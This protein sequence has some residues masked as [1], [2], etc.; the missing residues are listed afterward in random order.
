MLEL[1]NKR[2]ST[3]PAALISF[4]LALLICGL[5]PAY[6]AVTLTSSGI[7]GKALPRFASPGSRTALQAQQVASS[8]C[9]ADIDGD[10]RDEVLCG[11]GNSLVCKSSD[12][13]QRWSVDTGAWVGSSPAAWDVD[14][15][16]RMEIFV[17]NDSGYLLGFSYTG[18]ALSQWGWP[19]KTYLDSRAD[20]PKGVFSS[21]SI[22]DI[23]GDGDMEIVAGCWGELIWAWHYQGQVVGGYPID[24]RDTVWSSPA[25]GDVNGDGLN[26]IVIGA[27]CSGWLYP[28]GGL[29]Y[30]LNG[31]GQSLPGWPKPLPQVIWSSPALADLDGDGYLDIIVGTGHYWDNVDGMHVY[32][33]D[34]RGKNLP[35]WP[36]Y[37]SGYVFSSPAV[38]DV[39]GDGKL[40][41]VAVDLNQAWYVWSST[42]QLLY[43]DYKSGV[44]FGSP[45]LGDDKGDNSVDVNINYNNAPAMGDFDRDG[46][47]EIA[48][49]PSIL[50]TAAPYHPDKF[51]WPMFRRDCRHSACYGS[52]S[53][54]YPSMFYFA[55][56]Y[57]A[58]G[59]Q[60]YLCI[61]NQGQ[62][63]ADVELTYMFPGGGTKGQAVGVP[64]SSRYTINV[65]DVVGPGNEV[66]VEVRSRSPGLVVERPIYF[67]YN[68]AWPGGTDVVGATTAS[69]RWYFAE[70]TTLP[71]F[72]EYITVQN[73][74]S[75]AAALTFTYMLE[76]QSWI[77][78]TAS[79]G[80]HSRATFRVSDQVGADKNTS[81]LLTSDRFVVAERV[82][83]FLY[84]GAW[85][86]GHC[87]VG[88]TSPT[89]EWYFAEGTTRDGFEEWLCIQNPN[90]EAMTVNAEFI[91]SA[92]Q[93]QTVSRSFTI[94]DRRRL[95]V[96]V[97]D[98]IGPGKDVS[99][100]LTSGYPFIAERP[101]YFNYHGWCDGGHDVL[102]ANRPKRTWNFA[103]GYTGPGFEEYICIQNPTEGT[104][105]VNITYYPEGGTPV[106]R[107]HGV[108]P[109]SRY[110]VNV[111]S[112]LGPNQAFSAKV[113]SDQ[114]IICERPIYFMYQGAWAGG[115][116][117]VG[118]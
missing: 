45:A 38:G 12:N 76:G 96:K 55:E 67:N 5:S 89:K 17:G 101:M 114:N 113:E 29:V 84:H 105:G 118:F 31:A 16:G 2:R 6:A 22:G 66:S 97:N 91:P 25:I 43:Q 48:Y 94:P 71:G 115:T 23:D 59:F 13:T 83:Y 100:K 53:P 46:Y 18:Q 109:S 28:Q 26:E 75:T 93:G 99:V 79:V 36:V 110:T 90:T 65:N 39:Q 108:G 86:G 56:G 27:D 54:T 33:W 20:K 35:G 64:A 30:V 3:R 87:V 19:K 14:G 81:L 102:G 116:D 41:V 9:A 63:P 8:P 77:N 107:A 10:G 60:E 95:T 69:D 1:S 74:D 112:D 85:R 58:N 50:Q 51:P 47:V 80:P 72:E 40:E 78:R 4:I 106:T 82:M 44:E 88:S 57:T 117:V 37:T 98:V 104:A 49:G 7:S 15:D 73:P 34:Y 52:P 21:P 111:N 92:G 24:V 103:E 70:G 11:D 32:A 68:G 61:E 42:G 62:S